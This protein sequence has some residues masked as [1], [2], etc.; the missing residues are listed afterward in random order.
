[1]QKS[2]CSIALV[3]LGLSAGAAFAETAAPPPPKAPK[4]VCR[5]QTPTGTRFRKKVCMTRE[6]YEATAE[7][8]R[9]DMAEIANKSPSHLDPT[10]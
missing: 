7:R 4:L 2:L 6:E 3:A 9:R 5:T 8:D 10:E 1:M